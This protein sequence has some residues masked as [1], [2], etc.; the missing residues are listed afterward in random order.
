MA[1]RGLVGISAALYLF[2]LLCFILPVN[3]HK[4]FRHGSLRG[5]E[6][7]EG[8]N[9]RWK[10]DFK[11]KIAQTALNEFA[12][13]AVDMAGNHKVKLS[14]H[15]TSTLAYCLCLS[16]LLSSGNVERNPGP[17][18]TSQ[19]G[20]FKLSTV[21]GLRIC[22]LNVR[23]LV[24]KMDEIRVFCETHLPHVLSLN[25][26]WLD[27]SISDSEIQLP[28]YSLVRRDKTRRNGG[29][30]IY[31]SSNLNYKV[32][33]E[34]END[35]P[36]I[37]CLWMEITPPKSKGFIFCSC[38]R[39]PNADNVATYV[40][41]LRNMLTVMAD[42]EKE[43]VITGDLNFDLKQSNKPA[44]TKR[45]MNMAKEFSL[46]QII[47][48]FTRITENSKTLIDLFFTS[49]PDLYVS[50]VI[51]VGFSD[52]S[53]TYA[54]RK[55]H[56][57]KPPPPRIIDTRNFKRFN[58]DA[59]IE[60]LNKVPWSLINSFADVED[61]WDSFKHLFCEV[62][63]THAP[64]IRVRV[65]GNKVPWLTREVKHLINERDRFH[66]LALRSNNELHWSSYKRLRNVVTLKLRK[67]KERYYN[68]LFQE[69]RGDSRGTWKNLKRLLGNGSKSSSATART[70]NEAKDKC[71]TFNSF[72][73]SCAEDLRSIHR[74]T[75]R[76][77]SKWLPQIV[78]PEKFN[79]RKITVTEVRKALKDLKPKKATGV[80]GI[81]SRLLKDGSDAL[82]YP[83]SLIFNLTIQQNVIPAEWK[84]AKVTPLH[85]SG[86][87]D[88]PRNYRPISVLPVVSKVLER[89]I[90][91]Q[92][93][94]FFDDH[95]LLCKLQSG[96]RRMH[97]TETAVTYFADEILLNMDKGLVTGSVFID[98]AKAFDTV[99]HDI[100]LR[101]LEYYGICEESLL[102]FKDYFTGRK[103]FV[104]IDSHSSEELAI[105]S[106]VPQGSILGPLLFI[107]YINDLPRCVKHCS[108]GLHL[109]KAIDEKK[110]TAMVLID[111]NHWQ[112]GPSLVPF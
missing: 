8:L 29:V 80:D 46:R 72:F 33:Q 89:L 45:F 39:P 60:D 43:I 59:F 13:R 95:N 88:D 14:K 21:K 35:Q 53:A 75:A 108:T 83:L 50:G 105:T 27:S 71:N 111:L 37:Q 82:A 4:T 20:N 44:S 93:A 17:K 25:E 67:E 64:R 11:A 7:L 15:T 94:S 100:L 99:D 6:P 65:R 106:G 19:S 77:F 109:F 48:N 22:N 66:N 61:A 2:H 5:E 52:H 38:Y 74:S 18:S 97:S 69:T 16:L 62:A 92:L 47:D 26:T 110:V 57:L 91:K 112:L 107:V 81:P 78:R 24:N 41:G 42:R 102:W 104:Q 101:K 49:R 73:V 55:L 79:L 1:P 30:L 85:K 36:D 23:S 34:F 103:Q 10:S 96:F 58:R 9:E 12:A 63:D 28:G 56:R 86:S 51:P 40:E 3:R 87:K 68:E 90:H 70:A 84:K 76:S 54:V 98:L 31:I 32:I